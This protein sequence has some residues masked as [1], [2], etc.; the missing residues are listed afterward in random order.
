VSYATVVRGTVA[1]GTD[2]RQLAAAL[3]GRPEL[4]LLRMQ[5]MG[6]LDFGEL[7]TGTH[8]W[9]SGLLAPELVRVQVLVDDGRPLGD[10]ARAFQ[11]EREAFDA[12]TRAPG[13]AVVNPARLSPIVRTVR[14][15]PPKA[16]LASLS[17]EDFRMG[18]G[19]TFHVKT[20]ADALSSLWLLRMTRAARGTALVLYGAEEGA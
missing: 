9:Q 19:G 11:K 16:G 18:H 6:V 4:V 1:E 15:D 5:G 10:R 20:L 13:R 7:E 14:F 12:A 2:K 17:L 3:E 8:V